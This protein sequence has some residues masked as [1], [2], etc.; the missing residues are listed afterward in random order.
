MSYTM[1][2]SRYSITH[3]KKWKDGAFA[4]LW[5]AALDCTS[6][7]PA[8]S[9][10]STQSK[11]HCAQRATEVGHFRKAFQALNSHC[12]AYPS[13]GSKDAMLLKHPQVPPPPP[14][15][16]SLII[17]L[18]FS[19]LSSCLSHSPAS[20]IPLTVLLYLIMFY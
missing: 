19:F 3:I 7:F 17:S 6:H 8:T 5:T 10:S 16:S 13:P 9:S 15:S 20:P 4:A 2:G 11:V 1:Q 12:L 14:S 18:S